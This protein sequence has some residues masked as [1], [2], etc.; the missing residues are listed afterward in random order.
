MERDPYPHPRLVDLVQAAQ[1]WSENFRLDFDASL[2]AVFPTP[3]HAAEALPGVPEPV[4]AVSNWRP[5]FLT[6]P[7]GVRREFWPGDAERRTQP[8]WPGI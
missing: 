3:G 7:E 1:D 8:V 5:S 2:Y 6:T 4:T